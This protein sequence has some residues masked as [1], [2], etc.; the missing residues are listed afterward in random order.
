MKDKEKSVFSVVPR[1]EGMSLAGEAIAFNHVRPYLVAWQRIIIDEGHA[2][3]E[4]EGTRRSVC[5]SDTNYMYTRYY[6]QKTR[7]KWCH[8]C[9]PIRGQ[10]LLWRILSRTDVATSPESGNR[11]ALI[12]S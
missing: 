5:V 7:G 10:S 4:S 3:S 9:C 2:T 1:E 12:H 6:M 11:K 8:V